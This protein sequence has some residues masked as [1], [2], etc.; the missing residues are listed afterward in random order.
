MANQ[1]S[2]YRQTTLYLAN[3]ILSNLSDPNYRLPTE[4][5]LIASQHISRIT[6][7]KAYKEIEELHVITRVKGKGTFIAPGTTLAD[8]EPILKENR[9]RTFRQIGAILPLYDSPHIM[10]ICA[11]LSKGAH[12]MKLTAAYSNM[13]QESEQKLINEYIEMGVSGMIIY[14]VDNEIYNT[15][16]VN[17]SVSHFPVVMVDRYLPGLPFPRVSSDHKDMI[18]KAVDHLIERGNRHIL[19]FNSN[20]K[21][22]ST[23]GERRDEYIQA[24]YEHGNHNNYFFNFDGDSDNTS[25]SFATA[26]RD[27][28][29]ENP[30]ITAIIASDYASGTHLLQLCEILGIRFPDD[31][32]AVFLDFKKPNSFLRTEMPTFLEQDSFRLGFEAVGMLCEL[33]D[34]PA[35][36]PEN[37]I[38]PVR[39]VQGYSTRRLSQEIQKDTLPRDTESPESA[40]TKK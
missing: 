31:F 19:Y 27:Y 16:L 14:P 5:E 22:N 20:I 21:T 6:A 3:L 4:N 26:F 32:E 37:K 12:D 23:L 38:I 15:S 33:I 25:Q 35:S 17:L 34:H 18:R 8:L 2:L 10:E 11:A 30:A 9:E 40:P 1:M 7:R 13:D 29:K 36:K 24:L 28:L 39:L